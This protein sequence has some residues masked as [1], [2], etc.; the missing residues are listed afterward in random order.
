MILPLPV[1]PRP[2]EDAVRFLGSAAPPRPCWCSEE[3]RWAAN[4]SS[5]FAALGVRVTIVDARDHL[6]PALDSEMS[7]VLAESFNGMGIRVVTQAAVSA[8]A[9]RDGGLE[10]QLEDGR[11][12][13]AQKVL[14]ASGRRPCTEGLGLEEAGVET[15]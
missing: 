2:P 4:N 15:D 9:R 13:R 5:I 7:R 3:A 11:S 10:A 12:L 8:V 6:L 14:V 1:P